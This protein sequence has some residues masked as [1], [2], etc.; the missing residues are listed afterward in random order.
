MNY[1][2]KYADNTELVSA[3]QKTYK[4]IIT[5][6][7]ELEQAR[8]K[9]IETQTQK[10]L[11]E[12]QTKEIESVSAEVGEDKNLLKQYKKLSNSESLFHSIEHLVHSLESG[13][14]S[15]ISR[16]QDSLNTLKEIIKIDPDL[17]SYVQDVNS[18]RISV[19]EVSNQLMIY[20]NSI[21]MDQEKCSFIDQRLQE[22]EELKRKY[23]G[24][25]ESVHLRLKEMKED[26]SSFD[27]DHNKLKSLELELTSLKETYQTQACQL[28][29]SRIDSA[30]VLH[31][32]LYTSDA[33]DA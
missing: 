11:L 15:I 18:A 14:Q 24:S 8:K 31:C 5:V 17:D 22:I 12:F 13:E 27:S 26:L 30:Q 16:I 3:I 32:L 25:I 6:E 20:Q 23:G 1:L 9:L 7:T 2:D 28:H 19:Q 29:E 4:K 21:E 33:A 10:E